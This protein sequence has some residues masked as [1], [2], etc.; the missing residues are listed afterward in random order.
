MEEVD[1]LELPEDELWSM[2][3]SI[4]QDVLRSLH[5]DERA[6]GIWE[7]TMKDVALD[8]MFGPFPFEPEDEGP[9]CPPFHSAAGKAR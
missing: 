5:D 2:R 4:N 7:G 3:E 6:N 8:S 9:V 1:Q